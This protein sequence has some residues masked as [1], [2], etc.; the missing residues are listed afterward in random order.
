MENPGALTPESVPSLLALPARLPLRGQPEPYLLLYADVP[1][2][3]L[4][5]W[6]RTADR[7]TR[8]SAPTSFI[9]IH[10]LDFCCCCL[11][12]KSCLTLL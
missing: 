9:H 10:R 3:C 2:G 11:V 8:A 5:L 1:S 6:S 4:E 12:A 7:R